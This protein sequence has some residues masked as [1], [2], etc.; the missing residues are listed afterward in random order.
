MKK[1]N[2][3]PIRFRA[4]QWLRRLAPGLLLAALAPAAQAQ[5]V[6][7]STSPAP[8]SI[9][10]SLNGSDLLEASLTFSQAI[11]SSG[12]PVRGFR[13][14][15][16]IFG[17]NYQTASGNTLR[18]GPSRALQAG[19]LVQL[20]AL[21][22]IRAASDN[23]AIQPYSF[24]FRMEAWAGR[25]TFTSGPNVALPGGNDP[26]ALAI[27]DLN[28][29]GKPDV[30]AA[31]AT[32]NK[33]VVL[34]NTS[35]NPGSIT[36]DTPLE[37]AL[38][39]GSSPRGVV[40]GSLN[41]GLPQI[42]SVN[43][44][45]GQ[46]SVFAN[47][48]TASALSFQAPVSY[49]TG[50]S[51]GRGAALADLDQDGDQ[52]LAVA[53]AG[54]NNVSVLRWTSGGFDAPVL[55]ALPAGA[56]PQY[57]SLTDM[58]NDGRLDIAVNDF[59]TNQ[60][61][62][63]RNTNT[64]P[65]TLSFAAAANFTSPSMDGPR[66][67]AVADFDGDRLPD[68]A[69][70]NFNTSGISV[71]RNTSTPGT[72]S[73]ASAGTM[74]L[75]GPNSGI[76]L[77]VADVNADNRLD[78]IALNSTVAEL[79]VCLNATVG[80][81]LRFDP[82][83][84]VPLPGSTS[85]ALAVADLDLDG[86][87]DLATANTTLG[88]ISVRLNDANP[89]AVRPFLPALNAVNA[90][91]TDGVAVSSTAGLDLDAASGHVSLAGTQYAGHYAASQSAAGSIISLAPASSFGPG[92]VVQVSIPRTLRAVSGEQAEP[93]AYQFTTGVDGGYGRFG[94]SLNPTALAGFVPQDLLAA[95]M[96]G[97][98]KPELLVPAQGSAGRNRVV[99]L[100]NT[101]TSGTPSFA[102]AIASLYNDGAQGLRFALGDLDY[103][104]RLELAVT[105]YAQDRVGT[106][107]VNLGS[108]GSS[109]TYALPAGSGPRAVAVGDFDGDGLSDVVALTE[110][111]PNVAVL[112]NQQYLSSSGGFTYFLQG[113]Q[114]FG[115]L[116][117]G[118]D[119][120]QLRLADLDGDGRLDLLVL[121]IA[122]Q[123]VYVLRNTSTAAG[124]NVASAVS[125]S[126]PAGSAPVGL[127][128]ADL[129]RDGRLDILTANRGTH[130]VGILRNTSTVGSI[131]MA[132]ATQV[133][134]AA[135][136]SLSAVA[137]GDV[138]GDGK[139]DV[140]ANNGGTVN[141]LLNQSSVGSI[142]LGTPRLTVTTG[143]IG[144]AVADLDG[145][146]DLD[147]ATADG[148]AFTLPVRLNQPTSPVVL[149]V[150]APANGTYSTGSTLTFTVT[151][152]QVVTVA[153]NGLQLPFTITNGPRNAAYTSGSG[154]S[155][156]TFT[157]TVQAGDADADGIEPGLS[158][159]AGGSTVRN[160]A[161]QDADLTLNGVPNT[162]GVL[163]DTAPPTVLS[164]NRLSPAAAFT[165]ATTATF[166]VTFSE[167][168]MGVDAADFS[169]S[170]TGSA[171][172]SIA[173]V[174]GSGA[175]YDIGLSGLSGAGTVR[176]DVRASGTGITDGAGNPLSGGFSTGQGLTLDYVAPTTNL[177][178]TPAL[179]ENSAA[180]SFAFSGADA[181]GLA[182]FEASFDGAPFA[183]ASSP[184]TYT[185]LIEGSHTF[186]VRAVD[187]AGNVDASPATY[188]WTV[189]LTAPETN[190]STSTQAVTS[191]TSASFSVSSPDPQATFEG[192]LDGAP[193]AATSNSPSFSG[194]AE[195]T[196]TFEARAIDLA[197]NIDASPASFTWTV[198][199][200]SPN[201][202]VVSGPA[203]PTASTTASFT[204]GSD[205]AGVSY[206]AQLDGA[207]FVP[208]ANPTTYT[209]LSLGSHTVNVR[210]RD[211]AGNVDAS[212]ASYAWVVVPATVM[213]SISS[214]TPGSGPAGTSVVLTGSNFTGTTAVAFNG[215]NAS[216][217]MV[218]SSTQITVTVPAGAS[219]GPISVTTPGGTAASTQVFTVTLPDLVVAS[220]VGIQPG[221]YNNITVTSMGA[222]TLL[223]DVSVAGQLLV[224]AGGVLADNCHLI[225]GVGSFELQA[226][227][228][229][230]ICA[231]AGLALSGASGAVQV[232]GSRSFSPDASYEYNGTAPQVTGSG[233]P[234]QVRA[235]SI[236]NPADVTLSQPLAVV[237]Q[238]TLDDADLL[239]SGQPLT[240]LSNAS[241]TALVVNN[242]RGRVQGS[243][244]TVQRWIDPSLNPGLGYRHLSA[245]VSGSVVADLATSTFTPVVN[246]AYNV[247]ANPYAVTPFPTVFG[248]NEQRLTAASAT[249]R[250]F[251]FGW[252]SP[253]RLS[254]PLEVGRGY[255]VNL[256]PTTVDFTGTLNTGTINV[257]LTRGATA[258]SGLHLLGNP[259]PSPL[260][261]T[262]LSLPAG[263]DNAVYKYRSSS[264]Y[265]GSYAAYVNGIGDASAALLAQGQA[266][267][268]SVSSG[269]P[270]FS[271]TD[272][273]R[274]TTY[275]NPSL[276]RTTTDLRPQ[277]E[278]SLQ[279][280]AGARDVLYLY[281][282]AGAS[283]GFDGRYDALK[284]QTNDGLQPTLYQ[285]AGSQA[286]S[287]QGLPEAGR[288]ALPLGLYAPAAGTYT[289]AVQSLRNVPATTTVQLED[290]LTGQWHNLRTSPFT[291]ALAQG[292]SA[293][294]FVLHLNAQRPLATAVGL[295]AATLSV[296]PNPAHG[297]PVQLQ[298][299]GLPA[300]AK[301]A[302]LTVLNVL[303]Q[304]VH[305]QAA[306]VASDGTLTLQLPAQ[307]LASGVYTLRLQTAAGTLT[308]KLV[309]D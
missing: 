123:A 298:A 152:D 177:T 237:R 76:M 257:P 279:A 294:R 137:T 273:A 188:T 72:I 196:H 87:V 92:E 231:P 173:S 189:D 45:T 222:G 84:T 175:V 167:S 245:A 126:L 5:T 236:S 119:P 301:A 60:L 44:G 52:D 67:L 299:S 264:Q 140:L 187:N 75:P 128:V 103:N 235:L 7:Q 174:S 108:G 34:R 135:S 40:V 46:V 172:G 225:S 281:Q 194:L 204:F 300:S 30:V 98:G 185:G 115:A 141:V 161:G 267:F 117:A 250:A 288:F 208:V 215:I 308:R 282:E 35:P 50:G 20:T 285:Q 109:S 307:N 159:A 10:R 261:F 191:S 233:L 287:I 247:A 83:T 61:S 26:R 163:I 42:I 51:S 86:A 66:S 286:L 13:S 16:G 179:F 143:G 80:G 19:E 206:E 57:V 104:G 216:G 53:N 253:A 186:S 71:L 274:L 293:G 240:L 146:G 2:Y 168:V 39:A 29:D 192:R 49:A 25:G 47:T 272:A 155:T 138:D 302:M 82:A 229:L 248:Y 120:Q 106:S 85:V 256:A 232:S 193:F 148:T 150:G 170:R 291:V 162:S 69:T 124:V 73:M 125:L 27:M 147:F 127:A 22:A 214:F 149:S 224:Q 226:G 305:K 252:E 100:R 114:R 111:A 217:F 4:G 164:S 213:P 230:R 118:C 284:L 28:N 18:L 153:G 202:S 304:P 309:I 165:N 90:N 131:S 220:R 122:N 263:L 38:P 201:T 14:S 239:L 269:N 91:R 37:L 1:T 74:I 157:Y 9:A 251:D 94:G 258:G 238:L 93:F 178:S 210:A 151:F 182:R 203:N 209:G 218:N 234:A 62:V 81:M 144:L 96:N 228:T 297:Q 270:V 139:L 78:M 101:S 79:K 184:A 55:L 11:T 242:G 68:M 160:G 113:P 158:L 268:V 70:A 197:G 133:V 205:E 59:G 266:F 54:S 306:T 136:T 221:A 280:L 97:D 259:Y 77:A 58:D 211:A 255:T 223:G 275:Q 32:G 105:D 154:T 200:T 180:A 21:D 121:D 145:D 243:T 99:T 95:D 166:R 199:T 112:V 102:A 207:A 89:M 31:S 303:G 134:L 12:A 24:Q 33:I 227:A 254:A 169:L 295:S 65:G 277:L 110:Q 262:R 107:T 181:S 116:P 241:G 246:P 289:F 48:S 290:Q 23:S 212:P 176:L 260:D 64:T 278:L 219:T 56:A 296:Y 142:V 271:F 190:L 244:A 17:T 8:N 6:V 171:A 130:A 3:S 183:T 156:L 129:D 41:A 292:S 249:T 63:L 36:F 265:G 132:A 43:S 198:D 15:L 88:S 283:A 195:G 276:N